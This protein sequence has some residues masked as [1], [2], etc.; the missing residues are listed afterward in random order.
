MDCTAL[1]VFLSLWSSGLGAEHTAGIP[2]EVRLVEGAGRCSGTLEVKERG[3]WAAVEMNDLIWNLMSAAAVC[4]QLNCGSVVSLRRTPVSPDI[5]Y[6]MGDVLDAFAPHARYLNP[7]S[8]KVQLKCSDSVRLV[9]G[10]SV[11]SGRLE[12]NPNQSWSPVSEDGFD[13]Q[14]AEVVCRELGCGAPSDLQRAVFGE[15][16]A[17]TWSKEFQCEGHESALLDCNSTARKTYSSQAV[18]LTCSEPEDIRLVGG[19]SRCVGTV[20]MK[21]A[22]EWKPAYSDYWTLGFA[23]SVRLVNGM[24]LCSGR[25]EVKS[26][27]SWSSVCENDFDMRDAEVVCRELGCGS[28]SVLQGA[29]FGE[30]DAPTWSK[31]LQ[32][33]GHESAHW[34]CESSWLTRKTCPPGKAVGLTCSDPDDVRLVGGA[35]RCA[36]RIQV[37]HD[38]N[39]ENVMNIGYEW[40]IKAT[41]AICR[42]LDCGSSISMRTRYEA[43]R[44]SRGI[45]SS[46]IEMKSAMKDCV[47]IKESLSY[48]SM[49]ITCSDSIRLVN[50]IKPCSGRLEV[51]SDQSWSLMCE[52]DFDQSDAEVV[53]REVG[54][55]PPSVLQ[56]V[57]YKEAKAPVWSKE[58]HCEGNESALLNCDSTSTARSTCLPGKVAELTCSDN[59]RL[60]G[61][62]SRCAGILDMFNQG[63]W[64]P[65][66]DCDFNWNQTSAAA[67]CLQLGCGI[68]VSTRMTD[69]PFVRPVW[70]I[71]SSCMELSSTLLECTTTADDTENEYSL[72]IICSD[73]LAQPHVSLY[74]Y[75]NGV[76]EGKTQGSQV[77]IG[78]NFGILCSIKP[79][80]QGGS[81][82]LIF[83]TS[84]TT[85][86]YTM[87]AVNHTALFLFST[88]DHTHQGTYSCVYHVYAFT[89]NFSSESQPLRL[90]VLA[91]LT[92]LIIRL[93]ILLGMIVSVLVICLYFQVSGNQ[94]KKRH[95]DGFTAEAGLRRT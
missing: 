79:Q 7:S 8:F 54:C 81:F 28:P 21:Q 74:S 2:G 14:D 51:K 30:T 39:W 61:E 46:C 22:G 64:R 3:N 12:V 33:E 45:R 55:G 73:L 41:D 1:M 4:R 44:P 9:N 67:V 77:L 37:K 65:V 85:K 82:Q 24:N 50:G 90:S 32:C 19:G 58:F 60:V 56:G 76:S 13:Q 23:E 31:K 20:E 95:V 29:L 94:K 35:S 75:T 84:G 38:G 48:S 27:Q 43:T 59:I 87:P 16:D 17:P 78:S 93:V 89:F 53:C 70:C 88:A 62:A 18:A 34:D 66:V 86:N 15:T 92:D 40:N 83:S 10:T 71:K 57:L 42:W 68:V 6:S 36:G 11:C 5:L 63:E 25:L 69:G 91:S 52:H 49:E 72:E 80:Y 26:N 47:T